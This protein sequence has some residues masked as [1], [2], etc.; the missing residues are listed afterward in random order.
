MNDEW[1]SKK[2]W[3]TEFSNSVCEVRVLS[4]K[5]QISLKSWR[6]D[7]MKYKTSRHCTLTERLWRLKPSI[8]RMWNSSLKLK[9]RTISS[10]RFSIEISRPLWHDPPTNQQLGQLD[11]NYGFI[12]QSIR[13]M[14]VGHSICLRRGWDLIKQC[15]AY[16]SLSSALCSMNYS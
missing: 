15:S 13:K 2:Q 3:M 4:P 12:L 10:L 9:L 16:T 11:Q 8:R 6:E 1:V 14:S 7:W 5:G